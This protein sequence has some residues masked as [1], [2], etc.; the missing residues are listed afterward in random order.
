MQCHFFLWNQFSKTQIILIYMLDKKWFWLMYFMQTVIL[1]LGLWSSLRDM[2]PVLLLYHSQVSFCRF[3]I[4][5]RDSGVTV[6]E[7]KAALVMISF[8]LKDPAWCTVNRL[9][10]RIRLQM[11]SLWLDTSMECHRYRSD[12]DLL[13]LLF[14]YFC[15]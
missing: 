11:C 13:L 3:T 9:R 2:F 6:I 1:V 14:I 4:N 8:C 7:M 12:I 10:T 5:N 15:I